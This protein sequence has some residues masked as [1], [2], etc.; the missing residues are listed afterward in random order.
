MHLSRILHVAVDKWDSGG[1]L[2]LIL[3][4][5]FP[6]EVKQVDLFFINALV[7]KPP[8]DHGVANQADRVA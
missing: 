1:H 8:R 2:S 3:Q 7:E 4:V 6:E 5:V